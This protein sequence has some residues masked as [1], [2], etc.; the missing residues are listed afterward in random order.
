[1]IFD[2]Y[3][4]SQSVP[5][6]NIKNLNKHKI[7]ILMVGSEYDLLFFSKNKE[8]IE[9][10]TSCKICVSS[11]ETVQISEDKFLTQEFL[12]KNQLPHLK[13]FIPRNIKHAKWIM[14]TS[15]TNL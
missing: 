15:Y 2:L 10:N 6:P 7:D 8:I 14:T 4:I 1:M 9:K 5:H 3:I 11:I 12:K 13:T